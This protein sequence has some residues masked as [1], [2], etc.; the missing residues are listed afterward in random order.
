M[1]NGLRL[2]PFCEEDAEHVESKLMLRELGTDHTY[3]VRCA[4]LNCK[5]LPETD[6]FLT[7]DEAKRAWNRRGR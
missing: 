2:C 3:Q 6:W 5:I 4:N 7:K 1:R